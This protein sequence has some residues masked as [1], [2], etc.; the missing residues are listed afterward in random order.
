[1]SEISSVEVFYCSLAPELKELALDVRRL[2]LESDP[3]ITESLKWGCPCFA[4]KKMICYLASQA[5]Y[6]NFGFYQ[7]TLLP[8]PEQLLEGTGA[9]MRHIKIRSQADINPEAFQNLVR[10]ALQLEKKPAKK[11]KAEPK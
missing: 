10:E 6:L 4:G 3:G 5:N 7:A 9:K 8:D 1:M 2:V 11:Q